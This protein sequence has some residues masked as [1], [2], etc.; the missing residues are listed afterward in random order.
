VSENPDIAVDIDVEVEAPPTETAQ[1]RVKAKTLTRFHLVLMCTWA[2]LAVPSLLLW[3][4]SVPWLVFMSLYAN[5]VG[6]FSSWQ[7]ARSEA[8]RAKED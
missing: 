6:H 4:D 8:A 3:R 2:C 1:P 5:F 7:G